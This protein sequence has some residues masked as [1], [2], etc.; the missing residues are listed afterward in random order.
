MRTPQYARIFAVTAFALSV[1]A[2]SAQRARAQQSDAEFERQNRVA[3]MLRLLDAKPGSVIADVGA[4]DGMFTIPIARAVEPNGRAVAVDISESALAKLR[5]RAARQNTD[6]VEPILGAADDPHLTP[7]QFD[8]ALIHNAYHE[9]TEHEA[10]LRHIFDALKP[11]GHLLIVE[12]M[13]DSSKGLPRDQ[14][15]AK[16][17]IEIDVVEQELRTAGFD[18]R[19]RDETFI[20]FTVVP[21]EFW[22]ILAQRK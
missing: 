16:H 18:I 8:A 7:G 2:V 20:K 11:G 12:P 21:G 14:Q 15:V 19:E 22:L 5:E 13:H 4:G 3:E 17:D 9:M 10:M 6:N 1:C